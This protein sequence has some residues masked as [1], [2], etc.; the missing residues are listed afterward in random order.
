MSQ[1]GGEHGD[2]CSEAGGGD[3]PAGERQ[4]HPAGGVHYGDHGGGGGDGAGP[5]LQLTI[6]R[7]AVLTLTPGTSN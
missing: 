1:G 5:V 2:E 4:Q 6:P 7:L 3:G